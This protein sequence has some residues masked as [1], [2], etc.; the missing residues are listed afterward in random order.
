MSLAEPV[1]PA[2]Y[3]RHLNVLTHDN[4]ARSFATLIWRRLFQCVFAAYAFTR[5]LFKSASAVCSLALRFRMRDVHRAALV[6]IIFMPFLHATP[7]LGIS[8]RRLNPVMITL[9]SKVIA[10]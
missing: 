4:P 7:S 3:G 2:A 8:I 10:K 5:N 9:R 1:A 6:S